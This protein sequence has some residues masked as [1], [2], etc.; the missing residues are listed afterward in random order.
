MKWG[1][2]R[3]IARDFENAIQNG[4]VTTLLSNDKTFHAKVL[5]KLP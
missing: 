1:K 4:Q 3:K 2:K 5:K